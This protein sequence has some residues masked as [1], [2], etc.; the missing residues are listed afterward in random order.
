MKEQLDEFAAFQDSQE[1]RRAYLVEI[2]FKG[3]NDKGEWGLAPG[4]QAQS[5]MIYI[6][7]MSF[8]PLCKVIGPFIFFNPFLLMVWGGTQTCRDYLLDVAIILR[9][10]QRFGEHYFN[11]QSLSS[12]GPTGRWRMWARSGYDAECSTSRNK[13]VEGGDI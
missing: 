2:T 6:I 10:W 12:T 11:W 8:I 5:S 13:T 7:V 3:R 9:Y 1:M 4:A